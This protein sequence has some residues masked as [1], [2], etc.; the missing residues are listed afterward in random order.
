VNSSTVR[1]KYVVISAA[2]QLVALLPLFAIALSFGRMAEKIDAHEKRLDRIEN[3]VLVQVKKLDHDAGNFYTSFGVS[4][5]T[6]SEVMSGQSVI[7]DMTLFPRDTKKEKP[8]VYQSDF[9]CAHD[10]LTS[11]FWLKSLVDSS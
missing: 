10:N 8:A 7:L 5:K 6:V 11:I 9:S 1:E 3:K 2:L 4:R